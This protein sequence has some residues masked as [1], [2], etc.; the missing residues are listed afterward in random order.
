[1]KITNKY[2]LPQPFVDAVTR[3]YEYKEKRYSVTSI[4]K[5]LRENLLTR[6]Y[7]NDIEQ[8][9]AESIWLIFGTAVHKVL[10]ESND[11]ENLLKELKLEWKL[12]NGYTLSGI[13]D[14]YDTKQKEVID[15]KTGSIWK[16]K[17]D[18]WSD[19]RKQLLYYAVL[20]KK[21][22]YEC[23]K[24]KNVMLLKDHSKREAKISSDYP[25]FP[26]YTK[27]YTFTSDELEQAEQEIIEIFKQI[28]SLE[29][30]LD[31][32]L[33]LCSNEQRWAK[34]DKWA[35]MKKGNKKAIRVLNSEQ[36]AQEYM[37]GGKGDYIEF[38]KGEDSKCLEYCSCAKYCD[39]YKEKY[40]QDNQE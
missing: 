15:Y 34:P 23:N 28:E 33:P 6:K 4:L 12:E 18:D 29:N 31:S 14:L 26:V 22:G 3:N 32:E 24:G 11:D 36:E 16:V 1:M 9:V 38:R 2:G 27:E 37:C 39:Y 19:Y 8:D 25:E 35:V 40:G 17:F 10:E 20:L 30:A 13:I 21:N 5:G 7:A